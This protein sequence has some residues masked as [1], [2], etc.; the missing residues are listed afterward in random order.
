[1]D[2]NNAHIISDLQQ[3]AL[4]QNAVYI[5]NA[6]T[7]FSKLT[8]ETLRLIDTLRKHGHRAI[9]TRHKSHHFSL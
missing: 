3:V 1:M 4:R 6:D 9:I 7:S 2:V 8:G 5:P